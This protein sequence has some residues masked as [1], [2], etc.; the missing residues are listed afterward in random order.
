MATLQDQAFP[1]NYTVPFDLHPHFDI[2]DFMSLLADKCAAFVIEEK[3]NK[4]NVIFN[5]YNFMNYQD[6]SKM[7][8][9]DVFR[10]SIEQKKRSTIVNNWSQILDKK[11]IF[12][13]IYMYSHDGYRIGAALN[14]Y[15]TYEFGAFASPEFINR[16]KI[17]T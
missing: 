9:V 5:T 13:V 7:S 4:Y 14:K 3:N 17:Q 11:P 10:H 8:L 2:N 6:I 1:D 16:N 12:M 15:G